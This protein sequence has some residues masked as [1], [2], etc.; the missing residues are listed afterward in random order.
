MFPLSGF[1][2]TDLIDNAAEE[3]SLCV[4]GP[5]SSTPASRGRGID[6]GQVLATRGCGVWREELGCRL[7]NRFQDMWQTDRLIRWAS[8]HCTTKRKSLPGKS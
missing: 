8:L 2:Y 6:L 5:R 7:R 4:Y 1:G 3:D